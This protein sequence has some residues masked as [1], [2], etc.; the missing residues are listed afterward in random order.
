MKRNGATCR[1]KE[2]DKFNVTIVFLSVCATYN[3][4]Y[5]ILRV[6]IVIVVTFS[7]LRLLHFFCLSLCVLSYL[8]RRCIGGIGCPSHR[9][10][11][12][13][14]F[15]YY[16]VALFF[17]FFGLRPRRRCCRCR[18]RQCVSHWRL[19]I[20]SAVHK[21][22][23]EPAEKKTSIQFALY[24]R[25]SAKPFCFLFG[26]CTHIFLFFRFRPLLVLDTT[27]RMFCYES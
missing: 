2:K 17:T 3:L 18:R 6:H 16:F 11:P 9:L 24:T 23:A 8:P 13:A 21:A 15:A 5:E 19:C 10:C 7:P 4:F 20:L 14:L 27:C 12:L 26:H 25:A 1:P 22:L